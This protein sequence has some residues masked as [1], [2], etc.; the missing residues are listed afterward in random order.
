LKKKHWFLWVFVGLLSLCW[1]Y[2]KVPD[3][4]N[5]RRSHVT[6]TRVFLEKVECTLHEF[7]S[8]CGRY[9]SYKEG[10]KAL[11]SKHGFCEKWNKA[12][13]LNKKYLADSWG[14]PFEYYI[15]YEV[16][17]IMVTSYGKDG[18]LGGRAFN[19]DLV[20]EVSF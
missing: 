12:K 16:R 4:I 8:L 10:L 15:D 1:G 5:V 6:R 2:F 14:R 19:K 17:K 20:K 11:V 3:L 7:K 13:F 9:P 18:E